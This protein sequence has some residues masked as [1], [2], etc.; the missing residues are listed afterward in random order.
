MCN[1]EKTRVL[2]LEF[3]RGVLGF[4]LVNTLTVAR[5][6]PFKS[7]TNDPLSL[8]IRLSPSGVTS[9]FYLKL[10]RKRLV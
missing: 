7:R 5:M 2:Y 6:H 1:I 8:R 10:R 9:S 3:P 4:C